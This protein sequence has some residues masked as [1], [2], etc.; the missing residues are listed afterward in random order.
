MNLCRNRDAD[1]GTGLVGTAWGAE[2][3][4]DWESGT[5]IHSLT[6]MCKTQ[7][8]DAAPHMECGLMPC[9]KLEG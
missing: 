7:R 3:G 1:A 9:D 8:G 4:T 6:A 2:G 5:H